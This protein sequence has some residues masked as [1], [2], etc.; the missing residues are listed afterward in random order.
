[1]NVNM[2]TYYLPCRGAPVPFT[3]LPIFMLQLHVYFS[4]QRVDFPLSLMKWFVKLSHFK[5]CANS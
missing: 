1:M 4:R 3:S 5:L 2:K